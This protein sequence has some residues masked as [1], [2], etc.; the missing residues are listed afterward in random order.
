MNDLTNL[1]T[2]NSNQQLKNAFTD[3]T[4]SFANLNGLFN[5]NNYNSNNIALKNQLDNLQKF[6]IE[7]QSLNTINNVLNLN[8]NLI[9]PNL[10]FFEQQSHSIPNNNLL[11]VVQQ[12]FVA[13]NTINLKK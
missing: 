12:L 5:S 1:I 2:K 10:S 3:C 9:M 11:N 8:N 6:Y 13:Q 7:N 4:N